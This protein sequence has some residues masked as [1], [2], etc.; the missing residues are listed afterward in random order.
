MDIF[1]DII[2]EKGAEILGALTQQ[3]FSADNAQSFIKESGGSIM[4][5]LES[6][7]VDLGQGDIEQK[8]NSLIGNI[9][10]ASLA[11]KVGISSEMAQTGLTTVAPIIMNAVQDKLGDASGIMSLLGNSDAAGDLLGSVKKFF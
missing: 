6:G 5:A 7:N 11:S 8:A 2:G 3:G 10:I 1:N 9:E 4:S